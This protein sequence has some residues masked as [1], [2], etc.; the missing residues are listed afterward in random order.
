[1]NKDKFYEKQE[2]LRVIFM[3]INNRLKAEIGS[4]LVEVKDGDWLKVTF[5]TGEGAIRIKFGTKRFM[6]TEFSVKVRNMTIDFI[7]LRFALFL[8]RNDIQI[9]SVMNCDETSILR[10]FLE[11]FYKDSIF[12]SFG[13]QSYVELKVADY[14]V[15]FY[16]KYGD[17]SF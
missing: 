2:L 5:I 12:E 4:S 8:R 16:K 6:I 17:G 9:I 3:P 1:M 10:T 7:L 11:D 13:D 15:K 14:I